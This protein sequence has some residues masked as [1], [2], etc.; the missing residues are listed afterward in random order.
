MEH[1]LTKLPRWAQRHIEDLQ[2]QIGRLAERNR[3]VIA[4]RNA[5]GPVDTDTFIDHH[6]PH[7]GPQRYQM[8]PKGAEVVFWPG[9]NFPDYQLG[10][11][12][13][14]WDPRHNA[15]AI[16]SSAHGSLTV[17]P[18][19]NNALRIREIARLDGTR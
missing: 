7:T 10:M 9:E 6:H 17:E 15:L 8:L 19:V 5:T 2:A 16:R 18:V 1:D 3:Q 13:A 4:E 12:A 11:L 14:R